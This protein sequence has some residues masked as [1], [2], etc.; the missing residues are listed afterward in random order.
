MSDTPAFLGKQSAQ[1]EAKFWVIPAPLDGGT[2]MVKGQSAAPA[3]VLAASVYV[4][5]YDE[6]VANTPSKEAPVIT[7]DS[8]EELGGIQEKCE[9]AIDAQ[10]VP[11]IIG[12]EPIVSLAGI[13][14]LSAKA[15]D[16]TILSIGPR[17]ALKDDG[18]ESSISY[19]N[20]VL[21]LGN[22]KKVVF[23]GLSSVSFEE[24]NTLFSDEDKIE[25]YF[26]SDIAKSED[27]LWQEDVIDSLST[28]VFL[29]IDISAFSRDVA[30]SVGC[31][32][33]GGFSWW[34]M[35]KMLKKV[36]SRRRIA[37]ISIVNLV[38]IEGDLTGDF[39]A[40]KLCHK[41]MAYMH[42]SGKMF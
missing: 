36:I 26:S 3:S 10:A 17:A 21:E 20:S 5:D 4:E 39:A 31:P 37:G 38:P 13:K 1:D 33:P 15:E 11:V 23:A 22:M 8:D 6:E 28:P 7:L 32:E 27:D 19:M 24:S 35:L 34:D 12:G 40:A 30:P 16:F 9:E 25:P 18:M 29:S 14:A 42:A 41:I 2:T